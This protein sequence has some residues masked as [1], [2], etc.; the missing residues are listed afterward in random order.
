M[1]PAA[2]EY[3]RPGTVEEALAVLAELGHQGTVLA[4]GPAQGRDVRAIPPGS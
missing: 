2:F 3:H 1:K 4:G